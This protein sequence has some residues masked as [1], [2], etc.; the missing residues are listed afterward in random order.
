NRLYHTPE[1]SQ[2]KSRCKCTLLLCDCTKL[3]AITDDYTLTNK[4]LGM[5]I[6]GEVLEICHRESGEKCALKVLQDCSEARQEVE[7]HWRVSSCPRIVP[8]IDVYENLHHNKKCLLIVMECMDGGELFS[9]IQDRGN[10]VFTEREASDIMRSVGEAVRFLHSINIA[11]RDIKPENLLYTSKGPDALIKLTDFGFAKESTALN[12]LAT[13]CFSPYYAAPELLGPEK[14]DKSC[15]M[16][17]LGVIMYILL[18]GYP[19]F[20]SYHGLAI[21]PGM[22]RRICRGQYDFPDPEWCGVSEEAKQLISHLLQTEPT[23]RLTISEFMSHPWII[24]SAELPQTPGNT[25]HVLHEDPDEG[26]KKEM[27]SAL[28]RMRVDYDQIKIKTIEESTN[29]LLLKRR[30][31]SKTTAFQPCG[32]P[33]VSQAVVDTHSRQV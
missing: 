7:L 31:K 28:Q 17:S 21:S 15:D 4:A 10:R 18:C 13:P 16:W 32:M 19:P 30:Q 24:P 12:S 11:H 25:S 9:Q 33:Q 20:F 26:E 5:G 22:K 8:V 1:K 29:P 3:N 6:N 14:Y 23:Q 27:T 2:T